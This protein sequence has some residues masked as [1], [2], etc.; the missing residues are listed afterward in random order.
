VCGNSARTD[1]RGGTPARAFPTATD[2]RHVAAAE[3]LAQ[4]LG[5]RKSWSGLY[6]ACRRAWEGR[7]SPAALVTAGREAASGRA[8][9]PG[10]LSI[11]V[12]KRESRG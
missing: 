12:L 7:V 3:L 10:A 6:A 9:N 1:L 11:T 8:R 4:D 5:N 2:L